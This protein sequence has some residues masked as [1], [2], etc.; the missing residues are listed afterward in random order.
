M[1]P[2]GKRY[3]LIQG[4]WLPKVGI[5]RAYTNMRALVLKRRKI[6]LTQKSI[7]LSQKKSQGF[8]SVHNMVLRENATFSVPF[9]FASNTG[10]QARLPNSPQRLKKVND[11]DI[12]FLLSLTD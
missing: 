8:L 2:P 10:L 3:A 4:S 7:L 12:V 1:L 11:R 6:D 5:I 9:S